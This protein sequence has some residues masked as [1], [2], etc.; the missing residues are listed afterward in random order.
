MANMIQTT[1]LNNRVSAKILRGSGGEEQTL[2]V[3]DWG[4]GKPIVLIHGWPLNADMWEYQ[5]RNLV[6]Q[7]FRVITYDRRGFGRSTKPFQGYN[8]DAFADD[9]HDILEGLRISDATLVGFSMGGG[10][11]ARYL[12]RHGASR[13]EKTILISSVLPYLGQAPDNPDGVSVNVFEEMQAKLKEDRP[14]FI[15]DFAKTFYGVGILSSPVS[16]ETMLWTFNMAMQASSKATLECVNAFSRTDFRRDLAAFTI[17]TL[18]IHGT[19]DKVVPIGVSSELSVEGISDSVLKRYDGA[20]HGLFVTHKE[21]LLEDISEFCS[22][23]RHLEYLSPLRVDDIL[24]NSGQFI[25]R[26]F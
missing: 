17:P 24:Q 3:Q 16:E 14:Q 4:R 15:A 18:I 9:L 7:G 23:Q 8:Y 13:I 25:P 26:Q 19:D 5:A 20:P 6:E 10:E 1:N 21:E 11:I 2:Y 22:S 12:R